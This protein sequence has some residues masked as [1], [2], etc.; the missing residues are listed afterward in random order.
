MGRDGEQGNNKRYP[1]GVAV[2]QNKHVRSVG[3]TFHYRG[4]RCR[5]TVCEESKQGIKFAEGLL[6]EIELK[7]DKDAFV[8]TDYFPDSPRGKMFGY[9]GA[10]KET[11]GNL[12]R[13]Y[14]AA[15]EKSV[16][17]G[18][19]SISTLNGYRKIVFGRLIP[20]WDKTRLRDLNP[21]ELRLWVSNMGI[22]AKSVRNLLSPLRTVLDEALNDELI[23]SNP[24]DRVPLKL[25]LKKTARPSTYKI[26]PFN[27]LERAEILGGTEG[28]ELNMYGF[29][30]ETGLR[31]GELIALEWQKINWVNSTVRIDLNV[32]RKTKKKP[33]TEAG[34]RDVELTATA[35]AYLEA[36]KPY[37]FLL[38]DSRVFHNPKTGRPWDTDEQIRKS[39]WTHLLKKAGVRYR[40]PYQIRHTY[41]STLVSEGRNLFWLKGQMGHE[42]VEVLINHYT[43]WIPPATELPR[44]PVIS[45]K[46]RAK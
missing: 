35:R 26:D 27:A 20:K 41:A 9:T 4:V 37:T 32:V 6:R 11:L 31:P 30:F 46:G 34:M 15:C 39:S 8:Y 43:E 13:A 19:M 5:E 44:A 1:R 36:Q 21:R 24:L 10:S 42:T 23:T 16:A 38:D 40:E 25:L 28:Q 29:W 45:M 33:K 18:N 7:I 3:I 12:L 14:Y 22:T 2:R 17:I